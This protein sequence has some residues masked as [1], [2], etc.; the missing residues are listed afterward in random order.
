MFRL[1][2][3]PPDGSCFFHAVGISTGLSAGAL[4]HLASKLIIE[5]KDKIYNGLSL[6][7]WIYFETQLRPEEYSKQ[8]LHNTWGGA[9]EMKL[10]SEYFFRHVVVY[11]RTKNSEAELVLITEPDDRRQCQTNGPI[12]LLYSF[13]NHFDALVQRANTIPIQL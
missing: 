2:K 3:V 12:Y 10:F 8:I 5:N 1:V 6:N 7:D 4:R 11:S 9:V 13:S